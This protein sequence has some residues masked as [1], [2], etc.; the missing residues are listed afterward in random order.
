MD[1]LVK[2][3]VNTIGGKAVDVELDTFGIKKITV[4]SG[5]K[6]LDV[7]SVTTDG[8]LQTTSFPL[9]NVE[10]FHCIWIPE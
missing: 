2:V 9:N 8:Q 7:S 5:E 4:L 6:F 3:T 10:F 1:R